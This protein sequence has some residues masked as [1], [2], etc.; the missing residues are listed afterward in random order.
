MHNSPPNLLEPAIFETP[1]GTLE[2]I[3]PWMP[4]SRDDTMGAQMHIRVQQDRMTLDVRFSEWHP[5]L[6]AL[7]HAS[8][9]QLAARLPLPV[10]LAARFFLSLIAQAAQERERLQQD[11]SQPT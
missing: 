1:D 7:A 8:P 9:D 6:H 2:S 10:P 3:T 5:R 11:A 4:L